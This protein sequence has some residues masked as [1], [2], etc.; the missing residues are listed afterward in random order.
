MLELKHVSIKNKKRKILD[1]FQLSI[2]DGVIMGF[3]GSDDEAKSILLA[4]IAGSRAPDSGEILL[5]QVP[6]YGRKN[7]AYMSLGYMPKKYGFSDLLRVEEYF[8]LFLSLYKINWRYRQRRVDEVTELLSLQ[9]YRTAFIGEMPADRLPFLCLGKCILH[10]PSWILLDEPFTRLNS[11]ARSQMEQVLLLLQEQGKT[12]LINSQLFPELIDCFSD[13]TII[14]DGKAVVSGTVEEVYDMA[15]KKSPIRMRVLA[16]ME[17]ALSVLKNNTLVDRVT[18]D[19]QDVIF[20]FNG[21]EREEAELLTELVSSGA[22]IHNYMK[23]RINPEQ[24]FRR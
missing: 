7:K 9:E 12:I 3:L 14:E 1:E 23:D 5:N 16:G 22:L 6:I 4:S 11:A 24:I 13:V 19:G 10:D 17:S 2:P 20:R 15:I 8:D 21:G 18:V